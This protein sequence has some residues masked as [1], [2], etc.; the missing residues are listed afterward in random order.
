MLDPE[1]N[2]AFN[3][4]YLE[5]DYDLSQV[6]FVTTANSLAQIPEPLRDRMEIIRLPGYVDHE[7]HAIARQFLVPRQL[8]AHGLDPKLVTIDADVIP[9]V[10]RLYTREAGVR[11][12]ERRIARIARKLARRAA[13]AKQVVP[14]PMHVT[15]SDLKEL[16]GV[17]PFDAE[18]QT[19]EDKVG[20]ATG[21]AYTSVGGDLLEIEVAVV[22]GRGR[23]QL[24]GTLG[25]VLKES[26]NAALTYARSRA[27][28]LG[29]DPEFPKTRD[30]HVHL[31]AGATP[32]DGPSAGIAIAAAVV[33]ALTGVPVRGDT[34]MT[35]EVTL[36]RTRAAD[37]RAEGEARRGAAR[38]DH[39]H[40]HP[41]GQRAR[42]RGD[43]R[44]HS[45]GA[46]VPP[47]VDDGSGARARAAAGARGRGRAG[48]DCASGHALSDV[49]KV[50]DPL[51]IRD[52]EFLG[53]MAS[54][55]GWRPPDLT[56][57]EVAFSGRSNVGKSS[58]L[59]A[60]VKRKALA[61]VSKTPG[62]TREINFFRVNHQFVLADL[63]GYG[64][65]RVA[66]T[67]RE[68]W[69]PLIEGYLRISAPLRG[70]VQLIDSRHP[71]SADDLLMLEF[72]AEIGAPTVVVLTKIDKLRTTE[73]K[74]RII[75]L[76]SALGLEEE[77]VIPFSTVA[78]V[79][80]D[81]LAE[82]VVE[83]VAQPSWRAAAA[84]EPVPEEA[85]AP[86]V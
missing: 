50:A 24:T 7:K 34:A 17:P 58:L 8:T 38:G 64:F 86:E 51:V 42:D 32:K 61:R 16:L 72:L 75:S 63:P 41:R 33:S 59:N 44:R 40:H 21:L 68:Q 29:I 31:P 47:R 23:L 48:G 60:L 66:K 65:A 83:L 20:V 82:A 54:P 39:A 19:L 1:Q 67:T 37:W 70:V 81:E 55:T 2:T 78:K 27:S 5:V 80:R 85:P 74:Q 13:A 36:A 62:K 56:L 35:G 57:P 12:L 73:L 25:D 79:G 45:R 43:P 76:T 3:D 10:T 46:A 26:A 28:I 52:I 9:A 49:V 30:I 4:H 18:E 77:Q 6:L 11:E 69:R 14:E 84:S 22:R 71:P 15:L 53:G